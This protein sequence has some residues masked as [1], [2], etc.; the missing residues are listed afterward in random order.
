MNDDDRDPVPIAETLA[1]VRAEFG[2]PAD[3]VFSTLLAR[4]HEVV[5]EDVAAHARLVTLRDGIATIAADS[6][7]W[8]SQLRY[9]ETAV[10]ERAN[11]LVGEG[12]ITA[13]KVRVD[14]S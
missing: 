5:G 13:V 10:R 11:G 8:A 9:L 4:W 2:L 3:E 14:A 1:T 6:P 7:L 12:T